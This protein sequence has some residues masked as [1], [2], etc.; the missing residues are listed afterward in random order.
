MGRTVRERNPDYVVDALA[1]L[2]NIGAQIACA[3]ALTVAILMVSAACEPTLGPAPPH[4]SDGTPDAAAR[5][6]KRTH[7][8]APA[9]VGILKG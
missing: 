7:V 8:E 5:V 6:P 4:G 1:P 3:C 9:L 2:R